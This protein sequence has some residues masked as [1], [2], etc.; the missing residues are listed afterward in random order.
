MGLILVRCMQ[1]LVLY[2]LTPP[3]KKC[4]IFDGTTWSHILHLKIYLCANRKSS[5]PKKS[6]EPLLRKRVSK[7]FQKRPYLMKIC[8]FWKVDHALSGGSYYILMKYLGSKCLPPHRHCFAHK[9]IQ[10]GVPK[11]IKK[12]LKFLEFWLYIKGSVV[13]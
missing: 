6:D 5:K 7:K 3:L 12:T 2:G 10:L 1:H 4:I 11:I 9:K 8:H 13:V